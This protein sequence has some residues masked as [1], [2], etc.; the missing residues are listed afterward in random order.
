MFIIAACVAHGQTLQLDFIDKDTGEAVSCRVEPVASSKRFPKTRSSLTNGNAILFEQTAKLKPSPGKYEFTAS[1]GIEFSEIDGG[2]EIDKTAQSKFDV[3]FQHTTKMNELNWYSADLGGE[4]PA[5]QTQRWAA[6]EALNLTVTYSGEN[7]P[8]ITP[9]EKET[10]SDN[11]FSTVRSYCIG[12]PENTQVVL[13]PIKS[14]N[15]LP[16]GILQAESPLDCIDQLNSLDRE[17][18]IMELSNI[19]SRDLPILLALLPADTIQVLSRHLQRDAPGDTFKAFYNPD[20]RRFSGNKGMGRL[21]E[22]CYWQALESG[23]KLR[24]SAASHFRV[25]GK[26]ILGYNRVYTSISP[27]QTKD[28]ETWWKNYREGFS[29][30]TN[31][32]LLRLSV[33]GGPPGQT[34]F[35]S[36]G[37][38]VYTDLKADLTVRDEVD[39]LDVIFNGQTKYQAKLEEHARR[40]QFPELPYEES[41]WMIVRVVTSHE[42]SYRFASTAPTFIEFD[43]KPRVSRKAIQFFQA[44]LSAAQ[45]DINMDP[46]QTKRYKPW[47]TK[48]QRF[49]TEKALNA[50][51]P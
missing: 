18:W 17:S 15:E 30:V 33:N 2:F 16:Q 22:Y 29:I 25:D 21:V 44:W 27:Q 40:G 6:A 49:W 9:V 26:T 45:Q 48:A 51:V 3:I 7:S 47:L 36:L 5:D 43:G 10:S 28:A 11:F 20:P 4:L 13:H 35:G 37:Q 50:T 38:A 1:R 32:P 31:G 14:D 12:T 46:E 8:A 41:G 24:P 23:F 42:N 39:Y 19:H 34:L